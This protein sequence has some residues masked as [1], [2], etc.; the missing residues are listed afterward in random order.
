MIK[1]S[2]K[3]WLGIIVLCFII[4]PL[5]IFRGIIHYEHRFWALG[6]MSFIVIFIGFLR[7]YSL[8]ELGFRK[9]YMGPSLLLNACIT[10]MTLVTVYLTLRQNFTRTLEMSSSTQFFFFYVFASCPIQELMYRSILHA[11]MKRNDIK[12]PI[13]LIATSSLLYSYLHIFYFDW[14]TMIATLIMGIVWGYSYFKYPFLPA[15]ALSHSI[16]G[17]TSIYLGFI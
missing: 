2:E 1:K 9:R 5:L 10:F 7:S 12:S 8:E 16:V 11:E 4:I 15:I 3:I 14:V 13:M 17:A 6:V